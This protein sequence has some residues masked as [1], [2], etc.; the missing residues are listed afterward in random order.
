MIETG[1]QQSKYRHSNSIYNPIPL[2][3]QVSFTLKV[4]IDRLV[5]LPVGKKRKKESDSESQYF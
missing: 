2:L 1:A 3:N 5:Y 4:D